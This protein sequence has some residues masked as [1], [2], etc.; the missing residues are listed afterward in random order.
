MTRHHRQALAY[1]AHRVKR[2]PAIV[3]VFFTPTPT[4]TQRVVGFT[5]LSEQPSPTSFAPITRPTKSVSLDPN[6]GVEVDSKTFAPK[7]SSTA[8]SSETPTPT[9][10]PSISASPSLAPEPQKTGLSQNAVAG[11]AGMGIALAIALFALLFWLWRRRSQKKQ[12]EAYKAMADEKLTSSGNAPLPPVPIVVPPRPAYP[13]E[14]PAAALPSPAQSSIVSEKAPQVSLRPVTTFMPD[15]AGQPN[16]ATSPGGA[17]TLGVAGAAAAGAMVGAAAVSQQ[18]QQNQQIGHLQ[19]SMSRKEPPPALVLVQPDGSKIHRSGDTPQQPNGPVASS[20]TPSTFT[21]ASMSDTYG[22]F[23]NQNAS[24]M[25]SRPTT[26]NSNA[27]NARKMDAGPGAF[28]PPVHRVQM[29]F[30][31]SMGDELGLRAGQLVRVLHEYD[32]GWALCVRLDRSQQGVCPRTCLSQRPVKPRPPPGPNGAPPPHSGRV[33]P[34]QT[35]AG[36]PPPPRS[37]SP[38]SF[39]APV[40]N[41]SPP[42]LPQ[43]EMSPRPQSPNSRPVSPVVRSESPS[44]A[45]GYVKAQYRPATGGSSRPQSPVPSSPILPG[46]P[47]TPEI[48]LSPSPD[49]E[50]EQLMPRPQSP[51]VQPRQAAAPIRP[52]P[53]SNQAYVEEEI[54]MLPQTRMEIK[55]ELEEVAVVAKIPEVSVPKV[56]EVVLEEKEMPRVEVPKVEVPKI[57][58]PQVEVQEFK[59]YEIPTVT[60]E[61]PKIEEPK[62]EEPKIEEPKIE[63]PK[64][65]EPKIEEPKIEAPKAEVPEIVLPEIQLPRFEITPEPTPAPAPAPAPVVVAPTPAPAPAPAPAPTAPVNIPVHARPASPEYQVPGG[66]GSF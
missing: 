50:P 37:Q 30:T 59:E 53:L 42:R 15:V 43:N 39:P 25:S 24:S 31:P 51:T 65:E 18:N 6:A 2:E 7:R 17:A 23:G 35:Q 28:N 29:D 56:P 55:D 22:P 49:Y 47:T 54:E 33:S 3:T 26:A 12:Q 27:A 58:I 5:T 38:N 10:S 4:G 36:P 45:G 46:T 32:D 16:S 9:A 13:N 21:E 48:T 19:R 52:S 66:F 44:R 1:G 57:E 41:Q 11:L 20:P 40:H 8:A 62:I 60:V 63:E 14:K 34:P 61:V 64:I